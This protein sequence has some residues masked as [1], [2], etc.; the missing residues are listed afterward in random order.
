MGD[1]VVV[2]DGC[3]IS[4]VDSNIVG[5]GVSGSIGMSSLNSGD[6]IT[7]SGTDIS[8]Y[9]YGVSIDDAT[10]TLTGAAS[11]AGSVAGV[12]AD[13]ATVTAIGA[14]VD[15]GATGT[16][17]YMVDGDY[18]WIYPLNAAG[19]VGVYAE[20]TEFRWDGGTSTAT[21]ALHAVES[22]GS[23]ENLTWSASTTQINAGSNAYVTSIGN[24]LDSNAISIVASATIDE[25]NLFS[26]DATH[27]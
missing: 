12:Y 9:A 5:T 8:G 2:T 27:L 4:D 7:L 21:T 25:A 24:T 23:V 16:G 26:L 14:S 17:L 11:V 18:S 3:D 6:D 22:V 15:G 13:S 10:L 19:D 1:N 20:N